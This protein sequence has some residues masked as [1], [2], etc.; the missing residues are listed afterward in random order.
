MGKPKYKRQPHP[1]DLG[2]IYSSNR[3]FNEEIRYEF[4]NFMNN[5]YNSYPGMQGLCIVFLRATISLLEAL[6]KNDPDS[7][8][9]YFRKQ[10]TH[11]RLEKIENL[12]DRFKLLHSLQYEKFKH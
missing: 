9:L 4:T 8:S 3:I 1:I 7:I 11:Q 2:L 5:Y 6:D 10:D 12:I